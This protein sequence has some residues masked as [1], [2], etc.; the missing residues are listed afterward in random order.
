MCQGTCEARKP[1]GLMSV[2]EEVERNRQNIR[3]DGYTMSIGEMLNL[4][5]D[6]EIKIRP[7]FQRLF[8]WPVEKQSRLIE[9]LLLD[10]PLPTI[11]V[12]K[13]DAG[14]WE[15]VDGLQRLSTILLFVGELRDEE[16]GDLRLPSVLTRTKYIPSLEGATYDALPQSIRLQLKRSRL[17]FRILLRESDDAVKYELFDRLNSGGVPTSPQEVRTALLI[18]KDAGFYGELHDFRN[19]A[20]FRDTLALTERQFDEQYDLEL[21]VRFLTF[22][23]STPVEL[24]GFSDIDTFL[25]DKVLEIADMEPASRGDLI[26]HARQVFEIAGTIGPGV[27]RKFDEARGRSI[28]AFSVSAFEATTLGLSANPAAWLNLGV[29]ER[30][31]LLEQKV[32]ALWRDEEFRRSSGA[33]VRASTRAPRMPDVGRRIFALA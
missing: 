16:T 24:A 33:G 5:R 26:Q 27:F 31:A 14:T 9:S 1:R 19:S 20:D 6:S 12:A 23:S 10:I 15:V 30:A 18:M 25:T 17:D 4:Y 2:E 32:A 8:R 3:S 21:L 28:G 29:A 22:A 13:T 11:F 7:E